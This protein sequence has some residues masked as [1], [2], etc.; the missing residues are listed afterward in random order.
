MYF[1]FKNLYKIFI[2]IYN[3]IHDVLIFF[4][5]TILKSLNF[6]KFFKKLVIKDRPKYKKKNKVIIIG[7]GP[8]LRNNI[9]NLYIKKK[10]FD[11][12]ALNYFALS[13]EFKKIKPNY[14]FIA[15]AVFWRNDTNKYFKKDNLNLFNKLLEVDWKIKIFCPKEGLIFFSKKLLSNKNITLEAIDSKSFV[16]KSEKFNVLSMMYELSTPTFNNVLI[17]FVISVVL[18]L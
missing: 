16:F 18:V 2:K 9:T 10:T 3:F 14:Y 11:I 12:Y 8:S 15:D 1:F 6:F 17:L 7:N 13:E 5:G 4:I